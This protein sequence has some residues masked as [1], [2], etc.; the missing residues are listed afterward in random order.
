MEEIQKHIKEV[1]NSTKVKHTGWMIL[2]SFYLFVLNIF[3]F[4]KECFVWLS[5]SRLRIPKL[6]FAVEIL[7]FIIFGAAPA[8]LFHTEERIHEDQ[9]SV[10]LYHLEDSMEQVGLRMEAE[11]FRRGE[12]TIRDSIREAKRKEAEKI[13]Q[14]YIAKPKEE[15]VG[16]RSTETTVQSNPSEGI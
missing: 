2:K 12:Q 9:V 3:L 4:I 7:I 8:L 11:G 15:N 14:K 5:Y 10:R 13:K 1:I 16:N 6:G